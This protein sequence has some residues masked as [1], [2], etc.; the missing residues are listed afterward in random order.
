MARVTESS[1][2]LSTVTRGSNDRP[3]FY[4]G[5]ALRSSSG[6]HSPDTKKA[7]SV[8]VGPSVFGISDRQ[9]D[10]DFNR[11]SHLAI[12]AYDVLRLMGQSAL[13]SSDAP[14][15][16]SAKRRRLKTVIQELITVSAKVVKHARQT[17]LNF[18][19]H[20]PAFVVFN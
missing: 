8:A 4:R 10:A 17:A 16:H 20:C 13:L 14:V 6:P 11:R 18:G 5:L 19:R 7:T 1:G 12:L 15:R 3:R 2:K 9:H